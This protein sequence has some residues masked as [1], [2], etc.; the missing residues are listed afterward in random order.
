M[1]FKI[2]TK[3]DKVLKIW[4]YIYIWDPRLNVALEELF[5]HLICFEVE[6]KIT[7]WR[8]FLFFIQEDLDSKDEV[9]IDRI[10]W[11]KPRQRVCQFTKMITLQ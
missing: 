7:M 4:R 9:Y 10:M 5:F 1:Q 11:Y 6:G 2:E 3:L 8:N